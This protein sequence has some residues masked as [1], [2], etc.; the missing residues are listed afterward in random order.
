MD[1]RV[2]QDSLVVDSVLNIECVAKCTVQR[3]AFCEAERTDSAARQHGYGQCHDVVARDD[4]HLGKS[5]SRTNLHLRSDAANRSRNR[6]AGDGRENLNGG[7][8]SQHAHETSPDGESQIDPN[9]VASRY[10]FVIVSAAS[11]AA[12]STMTGSC[13]VN[14]YAACSSTSAR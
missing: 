2:A 11:R 10:Q 12:T 6:S 9:N 3:D 1:E 14:W 7:V 4:A 5:F 8:S 13:G